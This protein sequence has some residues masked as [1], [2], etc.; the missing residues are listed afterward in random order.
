MAS[1]TATTML[2]TLLPPAS[3][4]FEFGLQV[5]L[6]SL[7][8][9]LI[10]VGGRG[11]KAGAEYT[12]VTQHMWVPSSW[13]VANDLRE[14]RTQHIAQVGSGGFLCK[15]ESSVHKCYS[16]KLQLLYHTNYKYLIYILNTFK[17]LI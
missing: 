15:Q 11:Q 10:T 1:V 13:M 4:V 16:S 6:Q 8:S 17:Y 9:L 3:L 7:F 14:M 5:A 2:S 12:S